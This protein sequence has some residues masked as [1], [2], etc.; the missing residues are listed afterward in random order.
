LQKYRVDITAL[1]EGDIAAV[2]EFIAKDNAAAAVQWVQEIERQIHSLERFPRRCPVIP[3]SR[4]LGK[5]YH[6]IIYGEY[7]TIFKI[8]G[9]RVVILRVI[10]GARLLDISILER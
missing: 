10:H 2:F 1:A 5:E 6:H 7:R 4:H 9:S 3:A 8:A